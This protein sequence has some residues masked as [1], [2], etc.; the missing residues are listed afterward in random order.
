MR[1]V[2]CLL[3]LL[4]ALGRLACE[5]SWTAPPPEPA[6]VE[7]IWRRTREGWERSHWLR[8]QETYWPA[9]HPACVAALLVQASLFALATT[10]SAK[11]N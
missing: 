8:E 7:P 10:S 1:W 6:V 5:W 11:D 9:I 3:L 4:L 2:V